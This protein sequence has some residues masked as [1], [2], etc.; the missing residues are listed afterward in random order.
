MEQY[1]IAFITGEIEDC[2]AKLHTEQ[3]LSHLQQL[4]P[5]LLPALQGEASYFEASGLFA[6]PSSPS[7]LRRSAG[8]PVRNR[9]LLC[10]SSIIRFV[11]R[12]EDIRLLDILLFQ[13][14]DIIEIQVINTSLH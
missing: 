8:D 9:S 6:Q 7:H 4:E 2:K 14:W 3:N 5:S 11:Q 10:F 13:I 12:R 1:V